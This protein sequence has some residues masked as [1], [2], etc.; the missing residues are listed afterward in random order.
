MRR[1]APASEPLPDVRAELVVQFRDS[2]RRWADAVG[3]E[4]AQDET[5][6]RYAEIDDRQADALEAGE[7]VVVHGWLVPSLRSAG[8]RPAFVRVEAD[9]SLTGFDRHPEV[10][11]SAE[12]WALR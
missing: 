10:F 9:G 6:R 11:P 3:L 12:G 1:R 8:E 7:P 5:L 4:P 2:A